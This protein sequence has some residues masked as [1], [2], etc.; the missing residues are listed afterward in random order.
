METHNRSIDRWG[1]GLLALGCL[2]FFLAGLTYLAV[3]GRPEGTG[4]EGAILLADR[5]AHLE[6]RWTLARNMWL[7]E[8]MAI[9]LLAISA[10]VLQH[11][12]VPERSGLPHEVAWVVLGVAAVFHLPMYALMLAGYPAAIPL[13]GSEPGLMTV[14]DDLANFIF[15]VGTV[16]LVLGLSAALYAESRSPRTVP[17]AAGI[18]GIVLGLAGL[19]GVLGLVLDVPALPVLGIGLPLLVLLAGYLG[20]RLWRQGGEPAS[21]AAEPGRS[22]R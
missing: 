9:V 19:A 10:F 18:A 21:A 12:R 20:W 15:H 17:N 5:V 3:Y 11:R 13:F 2:A 6:A 14:I 7:T 1:G 8:L 22:G 16:L 4:P